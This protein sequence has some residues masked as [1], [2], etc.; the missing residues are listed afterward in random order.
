M[1]LQVFSLVQ[2]EMLDPPCTYAAAVGPL[3]IHE[4]KCDFVD[5]QILMLY[6]CVNWAIF[7]V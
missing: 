5:D 7:T 2:Q 3:C 6:I 1:L 4:C